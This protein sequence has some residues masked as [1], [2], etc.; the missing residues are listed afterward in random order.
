MNKLVIELNCAEQIFSA[1][2]D[3]IPKKIQEALL[4]NYKEFKSKKVSFRDFQLDSHLHDNFNSYA[5]FREETGRSSYVRYQEESLGWECFLRE[6][7]LGDGEVDEVI[8]L[9]KKSG[10]FVRL[11][12]GCRIENFESYQLHGLKIFSAES[13]NKDLIKFAANEDEK[14][15]IE[16]AIKNLASS[17]VPYNKGVCFSRNL[18]ESLKYG[19]IYIVYGSEYRLRALN[20]INSNLRE[21]L[22]RFGVPSI[23]VFDI[24]L[25]LIDQQPV[26]NYLIEL[27]S[28]KHL[29][30]N[31]LRA[32]NE[33]RLIDGRDVD[34]DINIRTAIDFSY[35]NKVVIPQNKIIKVKIHFDSSPPRS[36]QFDEICK[37]DELQKL[38]RFLEENKILYELI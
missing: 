23:L 31:K 33:R 13:V 29:K 34:G 22:F 10:L 12:H 36:Y 2:N 35:F 11:Y 25:K 21:R 4:K 28:K 17:F 26:F 8:N 37:K 6:K 20:E 30:I 9:I 38:T 5:H 24:P 27:W 15:S 3:I 18:R 14:K 16:N 32:F 7:I 19:G 1:L